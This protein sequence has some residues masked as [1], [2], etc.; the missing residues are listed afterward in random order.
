MNSN[1]IT[2]AALA[3]ALFLCIGAGATHSSP[4][5][6]GPG[7]PTKH[8]VPRAKIGMATARATA[9]ARVPGAKVRDEELESEHGRLIYSFDLEAPGKPGVEEVQ[10]DAR[11]GR[12]VS[13]SHETPAA[14]RREARRERRA[15]A[16]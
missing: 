14:E 4:S 8:T 10:V 2:A 1:R 16:R 9:L 7:R 11:N 15:H 13:V 5:P 12:V 3:M 6:S